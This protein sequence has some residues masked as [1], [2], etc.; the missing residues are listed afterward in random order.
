MLILLTKKGGHVGW[1]RLVI[2]CIR[3]YSFMVPLSH[4]NLSHRPTHTPQPQYYHICSH[5][6][7]TQRRRNGS[8]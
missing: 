1:V 2:S 3:F 4:F 7:G 8:G 5:L 6:A